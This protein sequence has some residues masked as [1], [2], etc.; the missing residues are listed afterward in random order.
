MEFEKRRFGLSRCNHMD[1]YKWEVGG[2]ES[3]ADV[4]AELE[5]EVRIRGN[6]LKMLL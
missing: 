4:M 2:S 1:L 6:H 3:E 5:A